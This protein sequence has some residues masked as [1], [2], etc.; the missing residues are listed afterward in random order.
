[1][2]RACRIFGAGE[3]RLAGSLLDRTRKLTFRLDGIE[4]PAFGGDTIL[5]ALMAA[6][7]Q[8]FAMHDNA[9]LQLTSDCPLYVHVPPTGG[10]ET[11]AIHAARLPA[12]DGLDLHTLSPVKPKRELNLPFTQKREYLGS[13]E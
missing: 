9:P 2:I 11:L 1:M 6:G 7:W 5:S 10:A 3:H 12:S 4:I 8:G 13:L